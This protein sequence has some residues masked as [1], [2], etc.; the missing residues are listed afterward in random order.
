MNNHQQGT[1]AHGQPACRFAG[2]GAKAGAAFSF[3]FGK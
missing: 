2:T 3:F 1:L